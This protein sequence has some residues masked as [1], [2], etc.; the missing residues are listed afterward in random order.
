MYYGY[1]VITLQMSKYISGLEDCPTTDRSEELQSLQAVTNAIIPSITD[2]GAHS[3]S[4]GYLLPNIT[5]DF[6]CTIQSNTE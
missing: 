5:G 2:H 4:V 1:V 3:H 6:Y